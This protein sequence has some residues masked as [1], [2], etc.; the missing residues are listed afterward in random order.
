MAERKKHIPTDR[1]QAFLDTVEDPK[2]QREIINGLHPFFEKKASKEVLEFYSSSEIDALRILKNTD[3]DIEKRMPVKLTR[4]YFE[5]AKNSPSIQN[6]VKATPE[7]TQDL[8]GSEDPG[9]QMDYSPVEGLLHKYEICLLYTSD[10]A[11]EE[12]V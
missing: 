2:Y 4:H 9:N 8:H 11:D 10:A 3:R 1:E 5:V 7:E 6:I 12:D